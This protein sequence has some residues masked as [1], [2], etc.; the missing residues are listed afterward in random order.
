MGLI[1][2]LML[3]VSAKVGTLS[4]GGNIKGSKSAA[5][6]VVNKLVAED[7][8]G[9]RTDFNEQMKQG[10]SAEQMKTVWT[11]AIQHHGK[12]K[13]QSEAI[14]SQQEGYD[15]YTIRC[16]MMKS[17]MEVVVAYDQDGKI[18]GL[19]VRPAPAS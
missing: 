17:P 18:G 16:E 3:P 2:S 10:L 6:A 7:F 15:V 1:M 5:K 19:W 11:G 13:S 4:P 9:V 14:Q 12:Y 8:E